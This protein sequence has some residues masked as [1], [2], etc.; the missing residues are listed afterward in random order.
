MEPVLDVTGKQGLRRHPKE[1]L[2]RRAVR[3]TFQGK[4]RGWGRSLIEGG[5]VSKADYTLE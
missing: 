3:H 2:I 1:V 4:S 5:K